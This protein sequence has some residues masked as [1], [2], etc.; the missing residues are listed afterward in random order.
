[1]NGKKK[2]GGA[3]DKVLQA[4]ERSIVDYGIEKVTMDDIAKEAGLSRQT[5]Y[6]YFGSKNALIED[7]SIHKVQ[8]INDAVSLCVGKIQDP[9]KKIIEAIVESVLTIREDPISMA[10]IENN[11][12]VMERVLPKNEAISD[13]HIARWRPILKQAKED[14]VISED[15]SQRKLISWLIFLQVSLVPWSNALQLSRSDLKKLVE[16]FVMNGLEPR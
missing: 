7:L 14:G 12:L 2:N 6:R 1:M 16:T 13:L 3:L 9:K 11:R 8:E 5:L 4:A 15:I 10:L